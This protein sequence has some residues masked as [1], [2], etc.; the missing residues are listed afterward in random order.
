M[1]DIQTDLARQEE[2][3]SPLPP[4]TLIIC[5]R[6]RPQLL[7]DVV[8]SILKGEEVPGE[9]VIIDQSEKINRTLE[10][11]TTART[12]SIR[13][14][15]SHEVGL[16]RANNLGIALAS[17]EIIAFTHDDVLV[18][19]SWYA[20]L[21]RALVKTGPRSIVTGQVRVSEEEV[22]GGFQLTLKVEQ[23]SAIYKGRIKKDVLLPLNMAMYRCVP[24]GI[25]GFDVRIGPGTPFP[26][27]EDNDFG[28][29]LLE[30]GYQII[31]VPQA[32]I[33]HRS[34]REEKTFIP[35]RWSYGLGRGAFYAKH[36]RLRDVYM[37]KRML[38]DIK[39]HLLLFAWRI[40]GERQKALGD[41]ALAL[42]IIYGA[43]KWLMTQRRI[44]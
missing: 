21:V 39:I 30:A 35:L 42:G 16:S 18:A 29:R 19:P 8:E 14:V 4:T 37:I 25:G 41:A 3:A 15:W 11:F 38:N 9:L 12:C 24:L 5:S 26:A 31:Y 2:D 6:N 32:V 7:I 28:F 13:Y 40:R 23:A 44:N 36:L 22:P 1:M 10:T 17:N 43:I 20:T 34:F 33:Y 27:A